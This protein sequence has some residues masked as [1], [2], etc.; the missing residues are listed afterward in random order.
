VIQPVV[1]G[2]TTS[3]ILAS[4]SGPLRVPLQGAIFGGR[5]GKEDRLDNCKSDCPGDGRVDQV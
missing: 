1:G 3:A 5:W 4:G 2:L